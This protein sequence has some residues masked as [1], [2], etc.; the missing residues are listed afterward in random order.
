LNNFI[1]TKTLRKYIP[2]FDKD[3]NFLH[4]QKWVAEL[5]DDNKMEEALKRAESFARQEESY[6]NVWKAVKKMK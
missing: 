1:T 5:I 3:K 2:H 4:H 6:T